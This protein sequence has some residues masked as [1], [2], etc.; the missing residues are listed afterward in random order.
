LGGFRGGDDGLGPAIAHALDDIHT[1]IYGQP[2][3]ATHAWTDE[4]AI[5]VVFRTQVGTEVD[6]DT[7]RAAAT[8]TGTPLDSLQRMVIATVLRRTGETLLPLGR[9][10]NARLGLAVLAFEHTR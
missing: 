7:E 4:E 1:A 9:S 8:V 3:Q 10:A 5:L 6:G 2:P